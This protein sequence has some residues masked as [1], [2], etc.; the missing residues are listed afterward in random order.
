MP[1]KLVTTKNCRNFF[2]RF[3]LKTTIV[4]CYRK[5]STN[6]FLWQKILVAY[7]NFVAK[8]NYDQKKF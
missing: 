3:Y 8:L 7:T 4:M 6:L 2:Y 1:K 5:I